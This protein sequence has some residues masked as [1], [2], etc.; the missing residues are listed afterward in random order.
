MKRNCVAILG[1]LG[2]IGVLASCGFA[3]QPAA[4]GPYHVQRTARVG[5]EGGFDY[6]YAD[7]DGRRL[8]V[9][10]GG[11][12]PRVTVFDLDTLAT[13]GEIADANARGV[14]TDSRSHHGFASSSPVAMWD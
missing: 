7:V 4:E 12:A 8:Y 5:G 6:V 9:A 13:V 11:P 14:A 10:R 3:Q 1:V 2:F